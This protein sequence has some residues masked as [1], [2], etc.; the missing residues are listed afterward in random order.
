VPSRTEISDYNGYWGEG[1]NIVVPTGWSV[2][3]KLGNVSQFTRHSLMLVKT[4]SQADMPLKLS[5]EDAVWGV[6]TTPLEG[7]KPGETA[8]L[9]FV[10]KSAGSYF[11]ACARPV[12]FI[13]GHW[14]GFEVRDRLKQ[15]EAII[16]EDKIPPQEHPGRS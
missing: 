6:H 5:E 9:R 4:Y 7:I 12:H 8:E 15:A 13:E 2:V 14:I 10:A 3:I 1:L 11:L 16:H